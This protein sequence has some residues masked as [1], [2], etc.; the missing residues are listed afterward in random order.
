MNHKQHRERQQCRF[1]FSE[2]GMLI[3]VDL[4]KLHERVDEM[5]AKAFE[6]LCD[7]ARQAADNM[8]EGRWII[9][10]IAAEVETSYAAHNIGLMATTIGIE[11]A[12][13][14]EYERVHKFYE[15]LA[16]ANY[17]AENPMLRYSHYRA[18]MRLKDPIKAI[19]F[20]DRCSSDGL[21]IEQ[22]TVEITRLLGKPVSPKKIIEFE[23]EW[24]DMLNNLRTA[25]MARA[26][27]HPARVRVTITEV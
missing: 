23:C 18:A 27:E 2:V 19:A 11:K 22:A 3:D 8:E 7:E 10:R 4:D 9:G 20:L 25:M 5:E 17:R 14:W 1:L 16:P 13:V 15:N 24:S 26:G 12:R 21:T 6:A